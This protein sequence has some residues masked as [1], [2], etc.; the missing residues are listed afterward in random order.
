MEK[1]GS[2]VNTRI[3]DVVNKASKRLNEKLEELIDIKDRY[4]SLS[5]QKTA[6]GRQVDSYYN[7]E[8]FNVVSR[9]LTQRN[10]C[11]VDSALI[12]PQGRGNIGGFESNVMF[13]NYTAA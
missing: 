3:D 8:S 2:R 6:I 4:D 1:G 13:V 9:E 7:I 11:A 12:V 10:I 5:Q